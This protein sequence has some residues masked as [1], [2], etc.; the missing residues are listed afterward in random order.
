MM[1]LRAMAA[2]AVAA[3][4]VSVV[5]ILA[6]ASS[7]VGVRFWPPAG[8]DWRFWLAWV[9]WALA[10]GG[11]VAVGALDWGSLGTMPPPV[12]ALGALVLVAGLAVAFAAIADL[13]LDE[14]EG[15]AGE[16]QTG[17]LYR[18]TRNPQY[19][20][21]SLAVAG[22][23]LLADS[24]LTLPVGLSALAYYVALPIAEEPWLREQYGD[25]Y[26]EYCQ[27]VPRFLGR[28]TVAALLDTPRKE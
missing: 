6:S 22:W 13:G 12:R 11:L 21:D 8:R 18:F 14:T 2:L 16:L 25:R 7:R 3:N 19:V 15:L 5:G 10:T 28:H 27:R 20:G 26:L 4:A 1:L 23:L 9:L 24:R 17:G